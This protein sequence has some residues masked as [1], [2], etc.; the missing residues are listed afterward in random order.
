M[1]DEILPKQ[2]ERMNQ[3]CTFFLLIVEV[4]RFICVSEI[5]LASKNA[6]DRNDLL[7]FKQFDKQNEK[8]KQN[9]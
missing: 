8:E 5:V 4:R 6:N 3:E 2:E 7:L 1:S 9:T